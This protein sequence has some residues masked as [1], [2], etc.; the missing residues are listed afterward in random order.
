MGLCIGT[1][2]DSAG[3][4]RIIS[5]QCSQSCVSVAFWG[6]EQGAP[7]TLAGCST[8]LHTPVIGSECGR[9]SSITGPE[10]ELKKGPAEH[11]S[12]DS[13]QGRELE[14]ASPKPAHE[15]TPELSRSQ[16]VPCM[17]LNLPSIP[18]PLQKPAIRRTAETANI[19]I[20][21][22]AKL[23]QLQLG[24]ETP[25]NH[26]AVYCKWDLPQLAGWHLFSSACTEFGVQREVHNEFGFSCRSKKVCL[27]NNPGVDR[28]ASRMVTLSQFGRDTE[29]ASCNSAK[30]SYWLFR[31]GS[32]LRPLRWRT[33]YIGTFRESMPFSGVS[34]AT[35]PYMAVMVLLLVFMDSV[36]AQTTS[37]TPSP[38]PT[39]TM[40]PG[41]PEEQRCNYDAY[42]QAVDFEIGEGLAVREVQCKD[43]ID[44]L[45]K[46]QFGPPTEWEMFNAI[47]KG[48]CRSY[49][50]RLLRIRSASNCDCARI[51]DATYQCF[52]T[53]TDYLCQL[54]QICHDFDEYISS[55][56]LADSCGRFASSED[57][58]RTAR[59]KCGVS[60]TAAA[61]SMGGVFA[62]AVIAA[63]L[64]LRAA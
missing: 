16:L 58:W 21:L 38:M 54:L 40:T 30:Y 12:E 42:V 57:E 27:G 59:S 64:S 17:D 1:H 62:A 63:T 20:I 18:V 35:G 2:C 3:S 7:S 14:H 9:S 13:P 53:A 48:E 25:P 41:L 8:R 10:L 49:S 22:A 15:D 36:Q 43:S 52:Y 37:P 34:G 6:R 51:Q 29:C 26:P 33:F 44:N 4:H 28:L 55:Y 50:D 45:R 19:E 46:L 61:M 31:W 60:A 32:I 11:I 47:C 23:T 5:P 56:C 24:K 39:P